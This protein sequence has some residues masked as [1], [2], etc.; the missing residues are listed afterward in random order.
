MV[1][2]EGDHF[3]EIV[4]LLIC[5]AGPRTGTDTFMERPDVAQPCDVEIEDITQLAI[6]NDLH[7]F[8]EVEREMLFM[9]F[10]SLWIAFRCF[11]LVCCRD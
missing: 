5:G 7:F 11:V 3:V 8:F 4:D 1:V 10:V 6:G 2:E 9:L